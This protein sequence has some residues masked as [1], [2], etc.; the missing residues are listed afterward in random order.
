[1][2]VPLVSRADEA[3]LG[4]TLPWADAVQQPDQGH[5]NVHP[6]IDVFRERLSS[7]MPPP[8]NL[9]TRGITEMAGVDYRWWV[10]HNLS[11]TE[12]GVGVG[13]LGYVQ[14][15]PNGRREG[16]ASLLSP[17]PLLSLGL[18]YRITHESSVY[19]DA[20]GTRGL[21]GDLS[22]GYVGAKIGMEW[23]SGKP[24]F[25]IEQG[26]V[27]LHLDSGYRL[28]LKARHGGLGLYLRGQF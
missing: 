28:A 2:S 12:W 23:K 19:A 26:A 18:R 6:Q 20:S 9:A 7:A 17:S 22:D 3:G 13:T 16:A 27:G 11:R 24:R 1:M 15:G 21:G 10:G 25:G 4:T 8:A 5:L 14:P